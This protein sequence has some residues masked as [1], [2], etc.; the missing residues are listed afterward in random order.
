MKPSCHVIFALF[1]PA[2]AAGQAFAA[3]DSQWVG[4]N[5]YQQ[6]QVDSYLAEGTALLEAGDFSGAE[7]SFSAALQAV[8][9]NYGINSAAQTLPLELLIQAQLGHRNWRTINQYLAHFDW[10]N[11]QTLATNFES[12]LEGVDA[13]A[14]LYLRAA[15]DPLNSQAAHYLVSARN[16]RWQAVSAIES[17]FGRDSKLLAPWLYKIVLSHFYQGGSVKRRGM[18]SYDYK[19]DEAVIVNGWSLSKSEYVNKSYNIGLELLTRIK[20]LEAKHSGAESEALM[21]MYLG[22]WET[23]FDN[24]NAA[25]KYYQQGFQAL[26]DAGVAPEQIDAFFQHPSVLPERAIYSDLAAIQ[27]TRPSKDKIIFNAWSSNFPAAERP[28]FIKGFTGMNKK[29]H[30]IVRLDDAGNQVLQQAIG[31]LTHSQEPGSPKSQGAGLSTQAS[32]ILEDGIASLR[33]RPQL[34]SGRLVPRDEITVDY[35]FT[36]TDEPAVLGSN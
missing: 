26:K 31:P 10:L 29:I 11:S 27:A 13:L 25:L 24:E 14:N 28:P 18:T 1:L 33:L 3:E 2:F 17:K 16:L 7:K 19:S 9:V 30:G 6:E 5:A 22:D 36:P 8:K 20:G 35:F 32:R 15:A 23:L 4:P 34:K 12:Y 21:L